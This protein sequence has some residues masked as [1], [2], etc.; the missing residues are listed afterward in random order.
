MGKISE[1]INELDEV[2]DTYG[3]SSSSDVIEE[4]LLDY[5]DY[6]N[7]LYPEITEWEYLNENEIL[8]NKIKKIHLTKHAKE[9]KKEREIDITLN[10]GNMLNSYIGYFDRKNTYR[11]VYDN[12]TFILDKEL[13]CVITTYQNSYSYYE[14]KNNDICRMEKEIN[15]E[16]KKL[17][18]KRKDLHTKQICNKIDEM[19]KLIQKDNTIL[20]KLIESNYLPVNKKRN[21]LETYI[22]KLGGDITWKNIKQDKPNVNDTKKSTPKKKKKNKKKKE[23]QINIEKIIIDNGNIVNDLLKK[24]AEPL[25]FLHGDGNIHWKNESNKPNATEKWTCPV[26]NKTIY[27]KDKVSHENSKKHKILLK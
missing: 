5:S 12:F 18:E 4:Q 22:N 27:I 10:K 17:E 9:R 24:T 20:T 11:L 25:P 1:V 21:I 14:W 23:K 2:N 15:K 13:S 3:Y 8:F 16:I 6:L 26:C 19:K 7:D